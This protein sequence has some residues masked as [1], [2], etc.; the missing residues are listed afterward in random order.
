MSAAMLFDFG[1]RCKLSSHHD[2][3]W[4]QR[5]LRRLCFGSLPVAGANPAFCLL[6]FV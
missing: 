3:A 2:R 1:L 6:G 4:H 5:L